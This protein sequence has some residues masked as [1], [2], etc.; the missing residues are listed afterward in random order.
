MPPAL[1]VKLLRVLQDQTFDRLGGNETVHTDVRLIAATHRDLKKW[2]E[3]EKF[4]P[5]L[6]YRLSVFTIHLPTLRERGD[7]LLLLV[8]G[9][10]LAMERWTGRWRNDVSE[11]DAR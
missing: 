11:T 1:Q 7:D 5:D 2:S 10:L 6:F 9:G 8:F 3:E 4:R